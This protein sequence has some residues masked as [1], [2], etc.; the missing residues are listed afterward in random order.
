M[1][2]I[3]KAT[4]FGSEREAQTLKGQRKDASGLIK[5]KDERYFYVMRVAR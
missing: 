5:D 3:E 1:P 2:S 4:L